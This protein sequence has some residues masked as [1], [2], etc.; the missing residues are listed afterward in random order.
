MVK[1][2]PL[3]IDALTRG[4]LGIGVTGH[5]L[6]R[7]GGHDLTALQDIVREV[8]VSI[9]DA[10]LPDNEAPMRIV[11]SLA[12]GADSIAADAALDLG[13]R[14]DVVLPLFHDDYLT[15]FVEA[16]ARAD[17]EARLARASSIFE[18]PG[19]R[20]VEG[21]SAIAYERAGRVV[22]AQSDILLAV[23]DNSPVR[24]RGGAA[25]IVAEAV[26]AGIPVVQIDPSGAHPPRLLW[27]GFRRHQAV[28]AIWKGRWC[29]IG[30]SP[31]VPRFRQA[32]PAQ[33]VCGHG[34]RR[35]RHG[36]SLMPPTS[37]TRRR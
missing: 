26:L 4:S 24:G 1:S 16:D 28:P 18:L 22:L 7:L 15:D 12:D 33:S 6:S 20:N 3:R 29:D 14:L 5:R 30:E 9:G 31:M 13:W 23:W 2:S 37:P 21:G 35:L 27:D 32:I 11:T 10:A 34:Q 8:L 17:H 25:Q 36:P 19:D